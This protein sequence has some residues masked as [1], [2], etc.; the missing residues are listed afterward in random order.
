VVLD[1]RLLDLVVAEHLGL[2]EHALA[3]IAGR[4]AD[5]IEALDEREHVGRVL[6]IE[7]GLARE[8][9]ERVSGWPSSPLRSR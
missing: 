3:Q 8:V 7:L 6:G 9:L 1:D 5:G 4:D 2:D